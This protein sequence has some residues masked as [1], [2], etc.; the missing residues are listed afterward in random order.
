MDAALRDRFPRVLEFT[1][2]PENEEADLLVSRTGISRDS[3]LRLVEIAARTRTTSAGISP[4]SVTLSTRQLLAAASDLVLA[5]PASLAFTL[6]NLYP[7]EGGTESERAQI[8]ALVVGK[9]GAIG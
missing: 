1:Y 7:S 3:A 6:G 5:G 4:F 9:F 2:L 8:M